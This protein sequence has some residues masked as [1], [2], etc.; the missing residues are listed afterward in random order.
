VTDE[1]LAHDDATASGAMLSGAVNQ[2]SRQ[3]LIDALARIGK[4][5]RECAEYKKLVALLQEA[6]ERL[7]RGLTGQKAERFAAGDAQMSLAMLKLALEAG[8]IE[9]PSSTPPEAETQTV[10]EHE[11]RKPEVSCWAHSRRYWFKAL[12]SDPDR[13]KIGLSLIGELFRIERAIAD[14]PRKKREAV[15][16]SRSQL[17]VQKFF[18]W[19]ESQRDQVLDESP[20]AV[21]IRYALNQRAGL[22]RFLDDGRLPVHNNRSELNLRR[23][24]LGRRAWLFL[25]SED[26]ALSAKNKRRISASFSRDTVMATPARA[27]RVGEG[28]GSYRSTPDGAGGPRP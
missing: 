10:A 19:C 6:N 13:A 21:A 11:R 16:R 5:E 18:D 8:G 17:V 15:R 14:A 12:E 23:Q 22:C 28:R 9:T 20:V 27:T 24:V 25:G 4:L 3:L 2:D 1:A 26:G 7:Q